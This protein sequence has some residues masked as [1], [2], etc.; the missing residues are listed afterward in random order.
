MSILSLMSIMFIMPTNSPVSIL[1]C[2]QAN[3]MHCYKKY[4]A[5]DHVSVNGPSLRTNAEKNIKELKERV[6]TDINVSKVA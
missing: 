6:M 5:Y 4:S 3:T 1:K 2:V